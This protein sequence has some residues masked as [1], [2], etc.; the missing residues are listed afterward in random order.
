M[1]NTEK[2]QT[3]AYLLSADPCFIKTIYLSFFAR[4]RFSEFMETV[5]TEVA[6]KVRVTYLNDQ[7]TIFFFSIF[8]NKLLK[9][10]LNGKKYSRMDQVK[11]VEDSL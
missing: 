8:Q 7:I 3:S 10:V 1:S 5:F 9:H 2:N 6:Y 11:F 4:N